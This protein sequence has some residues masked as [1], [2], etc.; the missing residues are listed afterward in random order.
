MTALWWQR[1]TAFITLATA[2]RLLAPTV[3]DPDLWGHVLFG[4]RTLTLGLEREDPF[5]Y[6]SSGHGWI[7]HEWLSEVSFGLAYDA[8][9]ATGLIALK[10][11]VALLTVGLISWHLVR[12]GS[13]ALRSGLLLLPALFIMIPGFATVRPQMFTFLFFAITLILL[14]QAEVRSLNWLWAL[15][16]VLGV[17][18]NFHGGVLA[19]AGILGIWGIARVVAALFAEDRREAIVDLWRP[20]AAG[21][22]CGLALLLNPYGWGLPEFLLRTATV[23]RPDIM[24]WQSLNVMS[25]PGFIYLGITIFAA[26]TLA[27]SPAPRR[28]ALITVMAAMV[29]L[30]LTAVRHLQLFAIGLPILLAD[31]F[32]AVWQRRKVP[33]ASRPS[34]KWIVSGVTFVAGLALIVLGAR[35]ATCIKIDPARAI[36]YPVRAVDWL[37]R[38]GVQGN[39]ATYFDWGE[40]AIWHLYPD[41]KVGMDGRRETVYSDEIYEEY[42]AF[43]RG[44]PGWRAVIDRPETDLVMFSKIWP[45]FQLVDLDPGW[46]KVYEDELGGVFVRAGHPMTAALRA[47]PPGDLPASGV[48]MCV[49]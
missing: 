18:I 29:L 28:P 11:V 27:R 39:M 22:A 47:T 13:D 19:G 37:E 48:G 49:P 41:I 35:E 9:G 33:T 7:N 4:Q 38:S 10:L 21:V 14:Y 34:E 26:V 17:W 40:Y 1:I 23:P 8:G 20:V 5:S 30:P 16:V 44:T 31:D 12:R 2:W 46:E 42:L 3:A 45:A 15:P 6:L 36:A 25:V 24:E 32:A 43:Q